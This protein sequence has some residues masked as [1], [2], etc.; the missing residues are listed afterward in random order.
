MT[1]GC[2]CSLNSTPAE[3]MPMTRIEG[4]AGETRNDLGGREEAGCLMPDLP[5]RLVLQ[6]H[7]PSSDCTPGR[8]GPL[9][10]PPSSAERLRL[11]VLLVQARG[12]SSPPNTKERPSSIWGLGKNLLFPFLSPHGLEGCRPSVSYRCRA[13]VWGWARTCPLSAEH[14]G[15]GPTLGPVRRQI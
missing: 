11:R 15:C 6:L 14:A 8:P 12:G 13:D 4:S 7:P 9:Q 3:H 5:S 1:Q 10:E 2:L